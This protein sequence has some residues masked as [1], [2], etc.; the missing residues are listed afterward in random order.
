MAHRQ[1]LILVVVAECAARKLNCFVMEEKDG[2][3]NLLFFFPQTCQIQMY[4]F[5]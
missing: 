4:E 1:L 3:K 5:E 2:K